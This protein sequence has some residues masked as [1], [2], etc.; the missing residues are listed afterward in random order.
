[1]VGSEVVVDG[2]FDL[3][4]EGADGS[5]GGFMVYFVVMRVCIGVSG[6]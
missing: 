6:R 1:M 3:R 5:G 2:A 4:F